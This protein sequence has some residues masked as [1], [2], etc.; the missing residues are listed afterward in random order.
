MVYHSG[1][2]LAWFT[3]GDILAWFTVNFRAFQEETFFMGSSSSFAENT[4]FD[5]H[6]SQSIVEHNILF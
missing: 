3:V 2:V 6:V 4:T 5:I 1:D